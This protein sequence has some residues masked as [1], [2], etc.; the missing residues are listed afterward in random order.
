L[1]NGSSAAQP[2]GENGQ[3][4]V[5]A[6]GGRLTRARS[7]DISAGK[8]GRI[9]FLP[10]LHAPPHAWPTRREADTPGNRPRSDCLR[11]AL[12]DRLPGPH[13]CR[14]IE[15]DFFGCTLCAAAFV[16][17]EPI[18]EDLCEPDPGL[19]ARA[20]LLLALL[21]DQ[22]RGFGSGARMGRAEKERE[23]KG[24]LGEDDDE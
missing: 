13:C 6:R 20:I 8:R 1:K 7:R 12:A 15:D 4:L 24:L 10:S 17:G 18:P 23:R 11:Q 2:K 3:K 22:L 9:L 14:W 21:V 19:P 16:W 5:P